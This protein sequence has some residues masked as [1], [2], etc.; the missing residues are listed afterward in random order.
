MAEPLYAVLTGDLIKSSHLSTAELANARDVL[1]AAVGDMAKWQKGLVVGK[2]EFFRGDAW[3]VLLADPARSL[4]A[5]LFLRARL[6]SHRAADTR[7]AIG[8]GTVEDISRKRVSLSRGEAFVR[9]GQALDHLPALVRMTIA[10]PSPSGPAGQRW[11]P[12]VLQFCDT[13]A[14]SWQPRQAEIVALALLPEDLRHDQ[15]ARRLHSEVTKQAVAK[16]LRGAHWYALK[17]AIDEFERDDSPPPW[18]GQPK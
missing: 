16:S 10:L 7:V 2:A 1:L 8:L 12:I 9:S 4:R 17:A 3:Q 15:I 13:L 6:K 5:A 11:L 18:S 14:S